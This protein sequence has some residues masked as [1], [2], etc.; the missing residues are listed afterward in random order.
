MAFIQ[1][2]EFSSSVAASCEPWG[3][4]TAVSGASEGWGGRF[5]RSVDADLAQGFRTDLQ[6]PETLNTQIWGTLDQ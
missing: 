4:N 5:L 3:E 2:G 6:H 1:T